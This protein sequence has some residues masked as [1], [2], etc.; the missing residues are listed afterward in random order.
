M[1]DLTKKAGLYLA[2]LLATSVLIP[3]AF[4]QGLPTF[5]NVVIVVGENTSFS[6]S[7]NSSN[8]PYLTSLANTYGIAVNYYSDT[9]PSIGNYL[10]LA[11]G[12][13][14]T[15]DD[16]QTP[17]SFPVS[18]NNIALEVQNAGGTW[19]DYVENLP[20][21]ASCKG[22]NPGAYYVRHDPLEYMTT[23]NKEQGHF[24]CFGNFATDLLRH[25]LP[26]LSWLVPNGCDD[27]HDCSIQTFDNW[28]KD[29]IG[30]ILLTSSYFRPGGTGLLIIVFDENNDSGSPDCETTTEGLGCGGQVELV[31]VSPYS[32]RGYQSHGGDTRNYNSSYDEGDILRLMAEGLGLPTSNLGWATNG[33]PMADFFSTEDEH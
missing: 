15:D 29:E 26:T 1:K 10:N 7:Y 14:L 21:N 12:N 3:S 6:T 16:S 2:L 28:L 17:Q 27:A 23:L 8:M 4:C 20:T 13:I 22:L 5:G 25:Q 24:V 18:L 31:V 32:K 30:G 19:K 33:L 11:T 9:H